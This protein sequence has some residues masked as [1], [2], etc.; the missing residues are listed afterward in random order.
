MDQKDKQTGFRVFYYVM[1]L[2][3]FLKKAISDDSF[4]KYYRKSNNNNSSIQHC[5]I[6]CQIPKIIL[7]LQRLYL[8]YRVHK[9]KI[10]TEN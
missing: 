1:S 8:K 2:S 4:G 10:Y 9:H 5:T 3:A 6:F 7:L